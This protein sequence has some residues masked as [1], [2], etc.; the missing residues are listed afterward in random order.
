MKSSH[1]TYANPNILRQAIC[2]AVV[3][4]SQQ[5]MKLES[6]IKLMTYSIPAER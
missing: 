1:M 2:S 6:L 4:L 5:S 3:T